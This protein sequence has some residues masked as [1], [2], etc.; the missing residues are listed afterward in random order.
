MHAVSKPGSALPVGR[1][2]NKSEY[3]HRWA[4]PCGRGVALHHDQAVCVGDDICA[5]HA[6]VAPVGESL[7]LVHR[8]TMI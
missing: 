4:G 1:S 2:P 3:I 6:I 7:V 8:C 5:D